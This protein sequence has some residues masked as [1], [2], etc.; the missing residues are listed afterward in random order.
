[1]LS[2][3]PQLSTLL[4]QLL[5][6]VH[7]LRRL[8]ECLFISVF[9]DGAIHLVQYLFGLGYYIILGLTVLCSGHLGKGEAEIIN[10]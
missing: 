4:V 6:C 5:L 2:V 7:S 8:L 10:L 1:M 3:V 9:S